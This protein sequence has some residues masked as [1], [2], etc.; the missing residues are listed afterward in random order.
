M[1]EDFL[2]L[3]ALFD[4]YGALLTPKQQQC[5]QLQ[6]YDDLSLSEIGEQLGISRQAV[7]DNI[8]RAERAMSEYEAKLG[9][10][11]RYETEREV[12]RGLYDDIKA[13]KGLD[14]AATA[15]HIDE[16][17]GRLEPLLSGLPE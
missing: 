3:S 10:V 4:L 12:L 7:Y 13:L 15:E 6:L 1:L 8:H 9:L 16:I 5:L 2:H 17:L 11:A 14:R